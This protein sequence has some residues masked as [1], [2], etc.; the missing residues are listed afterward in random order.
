MTKQQILSNLLSVGVV[1]VVRTATA[2]SAIRSIEALYDGG[3]TV[4][5]TSFGGKEL[6]VIM[7][8]P[9]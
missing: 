2:E 7:R 8:K 1:P 6:V 9:R 3:I 4:A 5:E